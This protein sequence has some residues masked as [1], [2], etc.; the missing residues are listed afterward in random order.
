MSRGKRADLVVHGDDP[1]NAEPPRPAIV[2]ESVT[3]LDASYARNHGG[4]LSFRDIPGKAPWGPGATGTAVWSRRPPD[5]RAH[6]GGN[7]GERGARRL[8]APTSPRSPTGRR[9]SSA[10]ILRCKATA[11]EVVLAWGMT[12]S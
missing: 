4:F 1:L 9:P 5:R 6:R 7:P 10:S 12:A 2:A 11:D 8:L 3:S